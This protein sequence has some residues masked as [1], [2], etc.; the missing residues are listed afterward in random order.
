MGTHSSY[1]LLPPPL[2]FTL[3]SSTCDVG[4]AGSDWPKVTQSVFMARQGQYILA[5]GL[6]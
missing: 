5:Y 4:L 1:V 6:P 3:I 2:H